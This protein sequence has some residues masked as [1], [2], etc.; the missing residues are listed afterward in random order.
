MVHACMCDALFTQFVNIIFFL[1]SFKF[2]RKPYISPCLPWDFL[3]NLHIFRTHVWFQTQGRAMVSLS[4]ITWG[5]SL[6]EIY[7]SWDSQTWVVY[8]KLNDNVVETYNFL[9]LKLDI[10]LNKLSYC[11]L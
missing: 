1:F 7:Y 11:I 4:F 2:L 3:L 10:C 6:L 9:C 5:R 8:L